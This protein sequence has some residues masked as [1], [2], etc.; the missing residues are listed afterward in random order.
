[1]KVWDLHCDTLHQMRK[2]ENKGT[3]VSFEKNDLHISLERLKK[4]D[5]LLQCFACFV[6]LAKEGENP[7]KACLELADQFYRLLKQYP[8]DLMQ[9][10]TPDDIRRLRND[11][12]IGAM[13]TAEEGAVCMGDVRVLRML[14]QLGIRMMTL[15]WNYENGLASPN[16]VPDDDFL[17]CTAVTDKGLT[18]KGIEI[19]EEMERLHMIADVSHLSDRGILDVLQR[20][21]RPFAASHSGVRA[22]CGHVRNLTDEMIRGMGEKGC[23]V[24]LNYCP[25]FVDPQYNSERIEEDRRQGLAS[26]RLRTTISDLARQA[27]YLM[28]LGGEDIVALG[29]DFDGIDGSLEVSDAAEMQHMAEGFLAEGFTERETEKIFYKNAVNFFETNL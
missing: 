17:P 19:L 12:R 20:A 28:N 5:Y 26:P 9:I 6:D 2:A 8:D 14:Y 23:L 10:C 22:L 1:M 7:L 13:L 15:T 24:G 25:L 4:G 18:E 11:G 3:P 27:R 21:R 29:S 16:L